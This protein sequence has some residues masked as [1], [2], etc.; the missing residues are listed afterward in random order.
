VPLSKSC[1]GVQLKPVHGAGVIS[2]CVCSRS[3]ASSSRRS[4]ASPSESAS[5]PAPV[6]PLAG[7]SPGTLPN[8]PAKTG[9]PCDD[10]EGSPSPEPETLHPPVNRRVRRRASENSFY[11]GVIIAIGQQ[12]AAVE[13]AARN[14]QEATVRYRA[15][16]DPYLNVIVAQTALLNDQQTAVSFRMQ[17]MVASVQLI[18][19]LGGGWNAAQIPSSKEI[20]A[21]TLQSSNLTR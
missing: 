6:S 9:S 2:P 20:R 16:V 3:P 19:A 17:N 21:Q 14:L 1:T 18:K 11:E 10:R 4:P 8:A 15:E 5:S 12:D 13:A 7:R